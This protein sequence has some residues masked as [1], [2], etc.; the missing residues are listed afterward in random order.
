MAKTGRPTEY[1]LERAAAICDRIALGSNLNQVCG[2]ESFPERSTV[3][4]WL[5]KHRDFSDMY[6]RARETR[7]DTRADKIDEICQQV[8]RGELE[9]QAARVIIDAL[10]WQASK[11][12]PRRYGERQQLEHVGLD[13]QPLADLTDAEIERR[14]QQ[15]LAKAGGADLAE[16]LPAKHG[17]NG[18]N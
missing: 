13:R 12:Q 4:L 9:P 18:A 3:Y 17:P 10:K 14:F 5:Q 2:E 6:A 15:L 11:E 1:S 8:Q 7:A 16:I